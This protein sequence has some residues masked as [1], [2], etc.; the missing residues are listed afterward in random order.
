[1]NELWLERALPGVFCVAARVAGLMLVAPFFSSVAV[2]MRLK[3]A[4]TVVLTAL[5]YPLVQP[6][7]HPGGL[8]QWTGLLLGEAALGLLSGL[9]VQFLFDAAQVAGQV[10]GFQMGFSLVNVIDPQSQVDTPVLSIFH[11]WLVL[12]LFLQMNV[13][14]WLLRGIARSFAYLPAGGH[15]S[16]A[17]SS[18][19]LHA[20]GS[21]WLTGV[22]IA[23]PALAATCAADVV[24]GFL[25]KASPQL[26]VLFV[27]LSL[28][29]LL[30]LA[31]LGAAIVV[32]PAF[33]ES[34]FTWAIALAERVLHLAH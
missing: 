34:R 15:I 22:Q 23:A 25:G 2:P 28:K 8:G 9:C 17:A 33:M 30:G 10:V 13:H 1:M 32:W 24:L 27:G 6:P 3:A 31:V 29:N 7:V 14:H 5:L 12:L 4:L 20:A 18:E 19:L 21:M 11:Q 16:L 26:P